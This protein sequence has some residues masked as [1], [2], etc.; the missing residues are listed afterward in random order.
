MEQQ[1][2]NIAIIAHVDHGKTTLV[3]ALLKQSETN[4]G[5]AATS[6]RIMDSNELERERGITIFSKNASVMYKGVKINIIDTPGH[7]D[8]GGEVERVLKMAD[9]VLLLIDAKDGPMPQTRFVLKKA[10]EL[11]HKAIVVVNKID[12]KDAR[13]QEVLNATFDLFVDLGANDT[14]ANFPVVYA[15]A[16]SGKAGLTPEYAAMT[17]IAPLFDAILEHVPPPE[18]KL[19][20]PLQMLVVSLAPDSYKG[21]LAIG[22]MYAGTVKTGTDVMHMHRDGTMAKQ[23]VTAVLVFDGLSRIEVPEGHAGDLVAIAGM[24][25]VMIGDTIADAN[26]PTA[27]P[28]I[29]IEQPTVKM[30][31]GVNTS[32]FAGREGQYSTSRNLHDRLAKELETD[33]ALRVDQGETMD[34]FIVSGRGELHLSILIEKMRRE[35]YEFHASRPEVIFHEENGVELEPIEDV[36]IDVPETYS[37]SIIEALGRRKGEMVNMHMDHGTCHFHFRVATRGLIGFRSQLMRLTRGLAIMNTL[38]KAYAPLV[39]TI[40]TNP[41]GSLIAFEAGMSI[42]YGLLAAEQRGALF[43]GPNVEVYAGMVVGENAKPEDLEVNVCK[44]K[45]LSNMRSKGDGVS[46]SLAPPRELSLEDCLEYI[47]AD[48]FVEVTP[49]SIRIRKRELDANKRKR[50]KR[51]EANE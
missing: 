5:K 28:P 2:R 16:I 36:W 14:Q 21:K 50:T 4:I 34:T 46:E 39:G 49:K 7:A 25:D 43:I 11:G 45:R 15:S 19:D 30:M 22:R 17:N 40:E 47:G 31:F 3:D 24:P 41:H 8:F 51:E 1:I 12:L 33:V 6:E 42:N 23:R 10:L 27:L 35:G 9:G 29:H 26:N 37:G 20:A 44:T 48:E 18:V 13:P 38:F 32:P